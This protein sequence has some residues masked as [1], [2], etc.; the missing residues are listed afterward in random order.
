[1]SGLARKAVIAIGSNSTRMLTANLDAALSSPQRARE[2]TRLFLSLNGEGSFRQEARERL[3]HAVCVLKDKALLAGAQDILLVATSA[4]R[5]S[6]DAGQLA[7]DLQK[8]TGL[9]LQILTGEEEAHFAF[10]GASYPY[11]K[12]GRIGVVDIGG[13]STEVALGEP[14]KGLACAVSLQMGASRL[15]LQQPI[16]SPLDIRAASLLVKKEMDRALAGLTFV[17]DRWLLVGGSGVA[18]MGLLQGTLVNEYHPKDEPFMETQAQ[19]VLRQLAELPLQGRAALMGMTIGR[20]NILPTGLVILT[21]LMERLA[22]T[23]MLVTTRNNCDG[24]LYSEYL[25]ENT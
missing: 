22:I 5:D 6:Q 2:E 11:A 16:D 4:V 24:L 21:S 1:M 18:L 9:A 15:Y 13:G 12:Q 25:K 7:A 3:L 19:A 23:K 10:L 17:S 8:K 20:E 14:E